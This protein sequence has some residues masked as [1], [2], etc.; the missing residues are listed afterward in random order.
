MPRLFLS[1]KPVKRDECCGLCEQRL[2]PTNVHQIVLGDTYEGV[3]SDCVKRWDPSLAALVEL[4]V[5]AERI[6]KIGRHSVFPPMSALPDLSR[7]AENYSATI[8]EPIR[9]AG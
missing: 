5:A 6:G 4:S 7:A 8:S 2:L 3:C 1:S 9:K